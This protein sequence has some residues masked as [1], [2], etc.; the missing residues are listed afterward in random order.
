M[1]KL[2]IFTTSCL[3]SKLQDNGVIREVPPPLGTSEIILYYKLSHY[4]CIYIMTKHSRVIVS[5]ILT[6]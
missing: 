6:K 2:N 1:I 4:I 5:G 3:S